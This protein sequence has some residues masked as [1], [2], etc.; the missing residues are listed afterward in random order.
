MLKKVVLHLKLFH[1]HVF[2][3]PVHRC[4][5]GWGVGGYVK[6]Q[7]GAVW[8]GGMKGGSVGSVEGVCGRVCVC[9]QC[10]R[11]CVCACLC[12]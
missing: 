11:V 8:K 10:G 3:P 6:G 1:R 5:W 7:C 2:P 12:V 9:V 4:V